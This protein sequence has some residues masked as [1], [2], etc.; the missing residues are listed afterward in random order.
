MFASVAV[1]AE[2]PIPEATPIDVPIPKGAV[3]IV[4]NAGDKDLKKVFSYFPYPPTPIDARN[5]VLPLTRKGVFR[6]EVDPQG[7][8][9]AVTTLKSMGKNLDYAALKTFVT[10]KGVPGS[11]RV[12]DITFTFWAS[13]RRYR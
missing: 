2:K 4:A 11:L 5:R 1:Q 9:A 8:V 10:W 13:G 7:K 6:L 3:H 12:V